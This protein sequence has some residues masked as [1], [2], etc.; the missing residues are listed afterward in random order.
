MI[1]RTKNPTN[2]AVSG[3][4]CRY[5]LRRARMCLASLYA[6]WLPNQKRSLQSTSPP[7][8]LRC[9]KLVPFAYHVAVFVHHGVPARHTAH[10][11]P[12][13]AAVPHR[14]SALNLFT[15]RADNVPLCRLAFH[16]VPPFVCR[17]EFSRRFQHRRIIPL[18]VQERTDPA[19]EIPVD[20]LIA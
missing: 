13:R 15:G 8:A 19:R 16:P 2:T 20:E 9:D 3:A 14:T 6:I 4:T 5:A 7:V 18:P 11:R 1:G 17:H 10:T 12:E